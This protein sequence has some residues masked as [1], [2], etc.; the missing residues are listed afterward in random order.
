MLTFCYLTYIGP[1][2]GLAVQGPALLILLGWALALVAF[3]T[4]PI[5]LLFRRRKRRGKG[6]VK[7]LAVIGLDGLE[8]TRVERLMEEGHLPN[9]SQ[10]AERGCYRRVGTTCPPLSPVAWATFSTGVNPGKHGIYG[11][12]KRE[13]DYSP[14]LAFSSVEKHP[15]RLGPFTLPWQVSRPRFLRKSKSFWSILGEHGVLSH[16]LRVP[17]TWPPE[18]FDGLM[19]SAMGAPDLMGTQGTYTLFAATPEPEKPLT[20]GDFCQLLQ[21][22][23][24]LVASVTGPEGKRVRLTYLSGELEVHGQSYPLSTD[25]YTPWIEL[26]FG[27][28]SGLVKFLKLDDSSFYMTAIQI[29]PDRPATP[30]STPKTFSVALAKLLGPFA[31]CGLAEDMGAR[32]DRTLTLDAFLTQSY[33]IHEE[34]ERQFFHLLNRTG[35]GL[36]L[37][38]FDGTDRIQHMTC[39]DHVLDELYKKM[40]TMVGRA[41]EQLKKEGDALIVL[42]DHG[43][44]P[45]KRLVDLNAWLAAEGYLQLNDQ[46]EIDWSRTQAYTLGLAG[47]SLNLKGREKL[48]MVE[49]AELPKLCRE[50]A[51]KLSQL[52]DGEDRPIHTVH[53]S[54]EC[55]QGPYTDAAPDLVIGY[56]PGYGINKEAARGKVTQ[57]IVAENQRPWVADHCFEPETVPGVLFSSVPLQENPTLSDLAPTI[58]ELFGVKP[59]PFQEG[60]SLIA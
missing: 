37:A 15:A 4:L 56:H 12:V 5:R 26:K 40:D 46:G 54:R 29:A 11:F 20:H 28:V 49:P 45:L 17:V 30:L 48:G 52:V 9:L 6:R 1:G 18:D 23:D 55:Y 58:L 7:R 43:F 31:T 33:E 22:G 57:H 21:Q 2:P 39:D 53:L 42:S 13:S 16:I 8:P 60:R 50:I 35:E 34:R 44:K 25:R 27:R 19:L 38:V 3:L 41:A 47:V 32:D 59:A 24:T 51:G 14:S 10:L 36:C